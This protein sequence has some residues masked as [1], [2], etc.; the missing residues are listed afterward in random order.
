MSQDV[1]TPD[2]D[3][4]DQDSSVRGIQVRGLLVAVLAASM[5]IP[6]GPVSAQSEEWTAEQAVDRLGRGVNFGNALESPSFEGEWGMV[7]E[8]QFFELVAGAG[9]DSIRLPVRWDTRA[10]A[11]APWTIDPAT[12]ERVDDLVDLAVANDLAII[13][14]FH[15]FEDL[16]SDPAGN[17]DRFV[18]LW[19]Q[20]AEHYRDAPRE[21]FFELQNEPHGNLTSEVWNGVLAAALTT[22][23]QSNPDRMVIVGGGMWNSAWELENL[24]LPDDPALIATFHNY[25]PFTFTHQGAEWVSG[26]DA[27]LG[28]TWE[29]RPEDTE[30]ITAVM[31][32]AAAWS[33]STGVPILMGEF[34]AY[35]RA[36]QASRVRYTSFVRTEAEARGFA[37]AYWEF[38]AGFGVYD[39]DA[40]AWRSD[41]LAA[42][43]PAG[44]E[45]PTGSFV[46]DDA[47]VFQADI[48]WLAATGVTRGCNPPTNDRFCPDDAVTRGQ[49]A[50]FLTRSLGLPAATSAGFVDV[51]GTFAN[52]IDRLASSGIT[53]G[54]N[55]PANDQFCPDQPVTRGQMAAFL[56]RALD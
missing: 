40:D 48:E 4:P 22:V 51:T 53:R 2:R 43:I 47:S 16:Y 44:S 17:A 49:M 55:P 29:G 1:S 36:D 31:D 45:P 34:G 52:D 5:F 54:C 8:D 24:E 15:H 7:I 12:F 46:D 33:D 27:W 13:L 25:E 10:A 20:I 18:A 3:P 42:L 56:R 50:A 37:W 30:P 11:T 38:G 9:F 6:A 35:S 21:V 39:R 19:R 26:S 14:D 32:A 41:L 23:R 28:T